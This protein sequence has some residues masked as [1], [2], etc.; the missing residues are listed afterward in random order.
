VVPADLLGQLAQL[1]KADTEALELTVLGTP[2]LPVLNAALV[3][4]LF[5]EC[6]DLGLCHGYGLIETQ[7]AIILT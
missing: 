5:Q 4:V 7:V 2:L 1:R 3:S 6:E